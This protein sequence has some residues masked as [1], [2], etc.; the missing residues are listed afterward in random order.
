MPCPQSTISQNP[1]GGGGAGGCRIQGPGPAALPCSQATLDCK[2][3]GMPVPAVV[4]ANMA[5]FPAGPRMR[6]ASA[7]QHRKCRCVRLQPS[8]LFHQNCWQSCGQYPQVQRAW[9]G[10]PWHWMLHTKTRCM[11]KSPRHLERSTCLYVSFSCSEPT[12][13][14]VDRAVACSGSAGFGMTPWCIVVVYSWRRLLADRHSLPF[15][16]TLSLQRR[17]CPSASHHPV[18]FLF[19]LALSFPLYFP[20]LSFGLSL[21]RP[22]C[23]STSYHPFPLHSIGRLCQWRPRTCPF[24]LL[25]ARES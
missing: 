9:D 14:R 2:S 25:C 18:T 7:L 13:Q 22:W 15:P 4:V 20:F 12:D 19:P 6:S 10:R 24:S 11:Q 21:H 3:R 1:G 17:W 8:A 5:T 16:W 23:P